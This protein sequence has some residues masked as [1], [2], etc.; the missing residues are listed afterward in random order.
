V[1]VCKANGLILIG[2]KNRKH[3]LDKEHKKEI[4]GNIVGFF[5]AFLGL[6]FLGLVFFPISGELV[7]GITVA[8]T[9]VHSDFGSYPKIKVRLTSGKFVVASLPKKLRFKSSAKV[10]LTKRKRLFWFTTYHIIEYER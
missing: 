4:F 2:P 9:V 3:I 1:S 6:I 7:K 5:I 8:P 10:K